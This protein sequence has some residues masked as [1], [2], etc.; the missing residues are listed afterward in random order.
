MKVSFNYSKNFCNHC[1]PLFNFQTAQ[2]IDRM[3]LKN[4][5]EMPAVNSARFSA[6]RVKT[7]PNL[8]KLQVIEG[9]Q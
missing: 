5:K 8:Y 9:F 1:S 2:D 3:K 6:R 4:G 7:T